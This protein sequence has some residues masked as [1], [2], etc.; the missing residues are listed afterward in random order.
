MVAARAEKSNQNPTPL[1]TAGPQAD[2][3]GKHDSKIKFE[4]MAHDDE[5][6]SPFI[7][8]HR[9]QSLVEMIRHEVEFVHE[10]GTGEFPGTKKKKKENGVETLT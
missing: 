8:D 6:R 2:P 4:Q 1:H 3:D 9:H 7:H 10:N 5:Y